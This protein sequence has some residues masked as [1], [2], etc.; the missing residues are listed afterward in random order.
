LLR[1]TATRSPSER[2]DAI[3]TNLHRTVGPSRRP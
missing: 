3:S 1:L 2:P